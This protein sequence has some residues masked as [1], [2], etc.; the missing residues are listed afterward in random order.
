MALQIATTGSAITPGTTMTK[1]PGTT[2]TQYDGGGVTSGTAWRIVAPTTGR[3]MVRANIPFSVN[4]DEAVDFAFA[5]NGVAGDPILPLQ[6]GS[7]KPAV[8]PL[9]A[10]LDLTAGDYVEPFVSVPGSGTAEFAI[11]LGIGH[12]LSM[13]QWGGA[14]TAGASDLLS[15]A[16]SLGAVLLLDAVTE[17]ARVL[18]GSDV[19]SVVNRITGTSISATGTP[20]YSA[21]SFNGGPGITFNGTTDWFIGTEAA[22]VAA[23]T[24]NN[25][26][27]LI[28]TV[29]CA[30]ADAAGWFFGVGNSGQSINQWHAVGQTTTGNGRWVDRSMN[31]AGTNVQ[32]ITAAGGGI[33]DADTD[34][35]LIELVGG[36]TGTLKFERVVCSINGTT[37]DPGTLTPNQWG[38]G[39]K[40][41]QTPDGGAF[42]SSLAL[43]FPTA[44][45]AGDLTTLYAAI[46]A[47]HASLASLVP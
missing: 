1:V 7:G 42:T 41:D 44:L 27:T 8:A 32:L 34:P 38:W 40:P 29:D 3:W 24:N 2:A 37:H 16:Q 6:P 11:R 39:C 17:S 4:Q 12:G 9:T 28:K 18:S 22:V 35:H 31:D 5:I 21:T 43:L 25:P 30:V 13:V 20:Q 45:S 23:M 10:V 15:V 33:N 36:D 19:T 46:A 47:H 14:V 26:Y